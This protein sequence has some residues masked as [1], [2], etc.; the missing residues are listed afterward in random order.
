M[1]GEKANA[2][3]EKLPNG[4]Y[5]HTEHKCSQQHYPQETKVGRNPASI[6][7]G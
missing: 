3:R 4:K 5:A 7:D 2:A 6:N 1:C